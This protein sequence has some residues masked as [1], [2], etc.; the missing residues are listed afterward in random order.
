MKKLKFYFKEL[1]EKIQRKLN[2]REIK[3]SR[4][5]IFIEDQ[6]DSKRYAYEIDF[7]KN[8]RFLDIVTSDDFTKMVDLNKFEVKQIELNA[9]RITEREEKNDKY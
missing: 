4:V 2:L 9:L 7:G 5:T 6:I 3:S 8:Y 1:K